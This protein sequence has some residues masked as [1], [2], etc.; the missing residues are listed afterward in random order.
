MNIIYIPVYKTNYEVIS[1]DATFS[2]NKFN[3]V[4]DE[5]NKK[6]LT[7][8]EARFIITATQFFVQL[9]SNAVTSTLKLMYKHIETYNAKIHFGQNK[10]NSVLQLQSKNMTVE[11]KRSQ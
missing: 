6:S 11:I 7:I 1:A 8:Y 5:K 10:T 9:L 2:M 3:L 4:V